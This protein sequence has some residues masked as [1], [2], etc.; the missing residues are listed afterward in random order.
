LFFFPV[1][2]AKSVNDY[3]K[4]VVRIELGARADDRPAQSLQIQPYVAD[5]LRDPLV[6][7]PVT[8]KALSA[9]RTFWEKAMILHRLYHSPEEKLVAQRMS[10]APN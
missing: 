1:A 5:V 2:V 8:V 10:L 7:Q 9:E 6:I 3:I 4:P